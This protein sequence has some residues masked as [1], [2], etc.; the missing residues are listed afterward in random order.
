MYLSPSVI[1]GKRFL[2]PVIKVLQTCNNYCL[3]TSI[4]FFPSSIALKQFKQMTVNLKQLF[5]A[6]LGEPFTYLICYELNPY[7]PICD[8]T[9]SYTKI[10]FYLLFDTY[11]FMIS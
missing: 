9:A 11:K 10:V 7:V 2:L 4:R 1:V 6:I 5:K 3:F 8:V